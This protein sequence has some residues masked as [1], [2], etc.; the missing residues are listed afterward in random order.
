MKEAFDVMAEHPFL[1]VFLG[2]IFIIVVGE[3]TDIFKKQK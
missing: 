2:F 3:I 1:T